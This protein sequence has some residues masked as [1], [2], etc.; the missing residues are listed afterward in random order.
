MEVL[1]AAREYASGSNDKIL[2]S[3]VTKTEENLKILAEHNKV[4][5]EKNYSE[6][7]RDVAFVSPNFFLRRIFDSS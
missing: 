4:D 3:L 1:Q 7:L 2:Q 5:P 6:F